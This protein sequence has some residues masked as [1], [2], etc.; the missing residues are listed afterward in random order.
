MPGEVET[1]APSEDS[2]LTEILAV[3]ERETEYIRTKYGYKDPV[4]SFKH[5][6]IEQI[7]KRLEVDDIKKFVNGDVC[8]VT[9]LDAFSFEETGIGSSRMSSFVC[10][11]VLSPN[12]FTTLSVYGSANLKSL[13]SSLDTIVSL[14]KGRKKSGSSMTLKQLV[15]GFDKNVS[16]YGYPLKFTFVVGGIVSDDKKQILQSIEDRF[17][18]ENITDAVAEVF[19]LKKIYD[20][21]VVNIEEFE[22]DIPDVSIRVRDNHYKIHSGGRDALVAEVSLSDIYTMYKEY[23]H[24][25]FIKNLRVPIFE[26]AYNRGIINTLKDKDDRNNFWFY[27]NGL[28]TLVEDFD[29]ESTEEDSIYVLNARKFQIVNGC[30]TCSSVFLALSEMIAQGASLDD[31]NSSSVLVRFIATNA[32][33]ASSSFGNRIARFTNSQRP[34]TARD[35]HATDP[36]QILVRDALRTRWRRCRTVH[37]NGALH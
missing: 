29:I 2:E 28:T 35:L 3:I 13:E 19:D 1:E 8:P 21:Y 32:V 12:Q 17:K 9:A 18:M 26:S 20:S 14:F 24:L 15:E 27:N 5:F 16:G 36:E 33:D 7:C 4:L 6:V 23:G 10:V 34:I 25:L 31:F 11:S 30:Q 22:G 37:L